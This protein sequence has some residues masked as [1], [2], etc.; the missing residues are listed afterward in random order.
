MADKFVHEDQFVA[1]LVRALNDIECISDKGHI[2]VSGA[3]FTFR[4]K[5]S[6]E[7]QTGADFSVTA[8]I[9]QGKEHPTRKT[10]LFQAKKGQVL[11]FTGRKREDLEK[12]CKDMLRVQR[13]PKIL[14]II[15]RQD[16]ARELRVMSA[17]GFMQG[18]HVQRP[19]FSEYFIRKIITTIDGDR[20]PVLYE[21]AQSGNFKYNVHLEAVSNS[22]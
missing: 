15:D 12:N 20:N 4:G 18:L 10:I 7:Y 9:R 3:T 14:E 21:N 8:D 17:H 11:K 13:G 16:G 19:E 22:E 1:A 5:K 6:A 2:K